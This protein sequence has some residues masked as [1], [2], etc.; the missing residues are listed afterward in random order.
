MLKSFISYALLEQ[1]WE[2]LDWRFVYIENTNN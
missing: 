1:L 2:P